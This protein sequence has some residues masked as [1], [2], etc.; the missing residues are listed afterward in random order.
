MVADVDFFNLT[1]SSWQKFPSLNDER[2]GHV[3]V[4]VNEVPTVI[5]GYGPNYSEQLLG[6]IWQ[7]WVA[8]KNTVTTAAVQ[9][10]S[11]DFHC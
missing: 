7:P 4:S 8:N 5:R 9:V 1:S 6:D 10:S 3:L 11:K 2:Y